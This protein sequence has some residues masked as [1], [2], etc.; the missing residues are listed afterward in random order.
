M[1]LA[2]GCKRYYITMNESNYE[3][4]KLMLRDL[5]APRGTEAL[6]INEFITGMI[7]FVYPSIQKARASG[8]PMTIV[9]F[10]AMVGNMMK[11]SQDEQLT[12]I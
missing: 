4:F 5:G 6:L 9:D 12:L 3:A 7:K 8:N 1:G 2:A 11:E 10:Y